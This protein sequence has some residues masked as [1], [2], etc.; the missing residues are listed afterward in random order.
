MGKIGET[1][2]CAHC[3]KEVIRTS[4]GQKYCEEC[5][6]EAR[7]LKS[8]AAKGRL[9]EKLHS[10]KP[11]QDFACQRCGAIF[12]S[13]YRR[14]SCE[15]CAKI[16]HSEQIKASNKA[17]RERE[18]EYKP[19]VIEIP[20]PKFKL[21]EVNQAARKH[22]MSY[23]QYCAAWAMG[24]VAEPEKIPEKKKRGRPKKCELI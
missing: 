23:G 20:K 5:K 1:M 22:N 13:R 19:V 14:M 3:G 11:L 24:K 10:E 16:I 6:I 12:Q 18:Q 2:I 15:E 8:K 7:Y 17:K 21:V 4:G 9:M